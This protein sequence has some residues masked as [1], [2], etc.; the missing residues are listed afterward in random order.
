MEFGILGPLELSDGDGIVE[1]GGS[2]Q[3]ALLAILL[4]HAN[5]VVS[6][7]RLIDELWGEASPESGVTALQVR[8]SQLR[9][10]LGEAAALVETRP[11]GYVLLG[12]DSLDLHR[13]ERLIEQAAGIE[14]AQAAEKLR[15]ALSLWRGP[16]LAEFAYEA[17]AQPAIGRLE[18]LRLAALEKRI[19]ADLALGRSAELA[20]ELE[21][22][23]REHPLRERF[24]G[25][26]MLA[27][28]RA[29]RQA[30]A[31]DAYQAARRTLVDG[32]GIEPSLA[33]QELEKAI[34][35]QDPDLDLTESPLTERSIL[36]VSGD[37]DGFDALL[38]LAEPLARRPP[39]ELILTRPAASTDDL[40]R[41]AAALNERRAGLIARGV[42]TRAAAFVSQ[43][44]AAEIVRMATEQD[45]DLVLVAGSPALLR[46]PLLEGVLADAPCDV[47]VVRGDMTQPGP[48]LVP[49]VGAE[50]DW[51]A[52]E[53]AAWIAG[54][55]TSH[56][57][58]QGHGKA[59]A[60]TTPAA[61]SRA[62]RWRCSAP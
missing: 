18:E 47:A 39:K 9:K 49:F 42:P 44:P 21:S 10:A 11:P 1:V 62:H 30:D 61:S 26:L 29:G 13:F 53:L 37:E 46:D 15:E 8:V 7:D 59:L 40:G 23:V 41:V 54:L 5:T 51:S 20:G 2:K 43:A 57:C 19:E 17:F 38:R 6:S 48:V 32:L 12:P 36:V 50:H 45:V 24:R 55:S 16:P 27:L 33:L 3:R 4:L 35:R 25:Q 56:S 58:S 14:P 60:D 28:Y 52:V 34:L 22:L 31:L